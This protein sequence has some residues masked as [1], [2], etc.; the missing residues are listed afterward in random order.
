MVARRVRFV[1]I[2][3]AA[4]AIPYVWFND[5][6]GS[7]VKERW[8]GMFGRSNET[9]ASSLLLSEH[10]NQTAEMAHRST[11]GAREAPRT[12]ELPAVLRFDITPDWVTH[13]WS[14]VSTVRSL[15]Q[16]EGLRVPLVT[17]TE[18]D[19][20]AGSLTYYFDKQRRVQRIS[21]HGQTGDERKLI[22]AVSDQF[23]MRAE[24]TLGVGMYVA[25]WNARP[26]SAL[27][28]AYAPVVR[29]QH[30]HQRLQVALEINRPGMQYG[31]SEE[32]D[33]LLDHDQQVKRW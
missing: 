9:W 19:D 1:L 32:F 18:I 7:A 4:V 29:S 17:G 14:R 23:G 15:A 24:P 20:L 22:A 13:R 33:R 16:L 11:G 28:I 12:N 25:R 21:F 8:E 10:G 31:F 2:L 27:R 30:P 3:L 26:T 5:H 6:L